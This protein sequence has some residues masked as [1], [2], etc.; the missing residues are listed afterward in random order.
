ME[1]KEYKTIEE[2]QNQKTW[3][4]RDAG[5]IHLY[6][7]RHIITSALSHKKEKPPVTEAFFSRVC[8]RLEPHE[9][10]EYHKYDSLQQAVL[11]I[12]KLSQTYQQEFYSSL[13]RLKYTFEEMERS[14]CMGL[15]DS[16]LLT[17][18]SF[19]TEK[20]RER[21]EETSDCHEW[22]RKCTAY[23]KASNL[24][25]KTIFDEL[26]VG[27]MESV[28][29]DTTNEEKEI[30]NLNRLFEGVAS[31]LK[32]SLR[33]KL[34]KTY[35]PIETESLVPTEKMIRETIGKNTEQAIEHW[36]KAILSLTDRLMER[37]EEK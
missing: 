23:F 20:F 14:L 11:G 10:K 21:R 15:C 9:K 5:L 16:P 3:D 8:V 12:A 26:S 22:L 7:T 17:P 25:Q 34:E 24:W 27:F 18:E 31:C 6:S 37:G 1:G 13:Y 32:K 28:L 33:N 30:K 19:L 36:Q 4:G 35:R 29:H 2:L